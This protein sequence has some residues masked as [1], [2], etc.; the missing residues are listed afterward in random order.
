MYFICGQVIPKLEYEIGSVLHRLG[1]VEHHMALQQS[2][3]ASCVAQ[4]VC[5]AA[6]KEEGIRAALVG[7]YR[8]VGGWGLVNR[9]VDILFIF[10]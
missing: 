5:R 8:S 2:R 7:S 4:V 1:S 9:L 3:G 6:S 10:S